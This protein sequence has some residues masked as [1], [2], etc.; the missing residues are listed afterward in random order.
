MAATTVKLAIEEWGTLP[1]QQ[2]F[3]RQQAYMR[4]RI[5]GEMGDMLIFTEHPPVYTLGRRQGAAEHLLLD[6]A[7]RNSLGIEL[8]QSNRGGDITY[9]GPGQLVGYLIVSLEQ[10]RDLHLFLRQIEQALINT[11]GMIG[12][13]AARRKGMTGIWLDKRK[14]A[15]IGVA[16]RQ[17][18]TYHGFA[19]NVN[20]DLEPF[21]GIVPCGIDSK[22]GSVTSMA[23]ELGAEVDL[24]EVKTLLAQE[25]QACL[26]V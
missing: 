20:N 7:E 13:A 11:L 1:Y 3:E 6:D 14:I 2:A 18:V 12:L 26:T 22:K 19:L 23:K 21:S 5:A 16:V 24:A 17:W 10:S 9:H 15:A 8:V 25:L 4:Q